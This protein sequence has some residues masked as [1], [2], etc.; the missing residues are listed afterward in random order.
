MSSLYPPPTGFSYRM[1]ASSTTHPNTIISPSQHKLHSGIQRGFKA[2][3]QSPPQSPNLMPADTHRIP[4]TQNSGTSSPSRM[5]VLSSTRSSRSSSPK[6]RCHDLALLTA[7]PSSERTSVTPQ[8]SIPVSNPVPLHHPAFMP[9]ENGATQVLYSNHLHDEG[10]ISQPMH[11]YCLANIRRQ[12]TKL[13]EEEEKK[14]FMKRL[15]QKHKNSG[16]DPQALNM[17]PS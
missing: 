9:L 16:H 15:Q 8:A 4:S 6:K 10:Y 17:F 5:S 3:P 14:A 1:Q 2:G 12:R 7:L 11:T 13:A